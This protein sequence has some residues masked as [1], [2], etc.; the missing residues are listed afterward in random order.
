M[1]D[2]R[3][4]KE[5]VYGLHLPAL[6]REYLYHFLLSCDLSNIIKLYNSTTILMSHLPA[7][8]KYQAAKAISNAPACVTARREVS[9]ASP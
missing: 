6:S 7:I 3:E 1:R 8:N 2:M 9:S 5:N 4:V